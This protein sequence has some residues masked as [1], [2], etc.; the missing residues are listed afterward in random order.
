[1]SMFPDKWGE[2]VE[3]VKKKQKSFMDKIQTADLQHVDFISDLREKIERSVN[4]TQRPAPEIHVD[5]ILS[6]VPYR[7][8]LENIFGNDQKPAPKIPILSKVYEESLMRQPV[9][10]EQ[11]CAMGEMCEARMIDKSAAFTCVELR[12]HDDPPTPQLCVLCSRCATQKM[13][14]DMC[15][16]NKEPSCVIQR[17]G[18]IFGQ[19]GEYSAEC[20]LSC[21]PSIAQHVMP[22]PVMS[23]QRNFFS[24]YTQGGVK[25]LRQE[26][27]G[28]EHFHRPSD[29]AQH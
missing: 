4:Q 6:R 2:K 13:F 26:R 5:H 14:Y 25:H 19:P 8:M 9:S 27:V 24:V 23:Y 22:L 18:N 29:S 11:P 3:H 12:L 10:Q 21:P 20:M 16:A 1:M 28:Y 17:Y 7:E 15:Y